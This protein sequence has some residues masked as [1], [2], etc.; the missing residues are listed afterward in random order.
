MPYTGPG[1]LKSSPYSLQVIDGNR[2]LHIDAHHIGCVHQSYR[3]R[4]RGVGNGK[5]ARRVRLRRDV[6][7]HV[8]PLHVPRHLE[9]GGALLEPADLLHPRRVEDQALLGVTVQVLIHVHGLAQVRQQ[10]LAPPELLVGGGHALQLLARRLHAQQRRVDLLLQ[11]HQALARAVELGKQRRDGRLRRLGDLHLR[12]QGLDGVLLLHPREERQPLRL[13]LTEQLLRRLHQAPHLG[14]HVLHPRRRHVGGG[15][16]GLVRGVVRPGHHAVELHQ[17]QRDAV[18]QRP[19]LR[20]PRLH[21]VVGLRRERKV[22]VVRRQ[23]LPQRLVDGAADGGG[24][25]RFELRAQLP[26]LRLL[27][28]E[29]ADRLPVQLPH[30]RPQVQALLCALHQTPHAVDRL[31]GHDPVAQPLGHPRR[32]GRRQGVQLR[33]LRHQPRP[34]LRRVGLHGLVDGVDQVLPLG[35]KGQGAAVDG[36]RH[37]RPEG[38]AARGGH[39]GRGVGLRLI[40][41]PLQ[42]HHGQGLDNRQRGR[43]RLVVDDA[44]VLLGGVEQQ[45]GLLQVARDVVGAP[46]QLVLLGD[47]STLL[48][49]SH[50]RRQVRHLLSLLHRLLLVERLGYVYLAQ[51]PEVV[52]LHRQRANEEALLPAREELAQ[53]RRRVAPQSAGVAVEVGDGR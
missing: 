6:V 31:R 51:G 16:A 36:R 15:G 40:G 38:V 43:Q 14:R 41:Q 22:A 3:Q 35:G 48:Q 28:V 34:G 5:G 17:R 47:L 9:V 18:Q 20:Q 33:R 39:L 50:S 23:L 26:V 8:P 21:A 53:V 7:Q 42:L 45:L 24:P 46:R 13:A 25:A 12:E 32:L 4:T 1:V 27:G 2:N 49:V 44:V 37:Q 10:R 19:R 52:H 11:L 30:R 29:D